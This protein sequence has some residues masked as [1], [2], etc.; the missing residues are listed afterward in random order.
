MPHELKNDEELR[1]SDPDLPMLDRAITLARTDFENAKPMFEELVRRGSVSAM[2]GLALAFV[3]HDDVQN[4]KRWYQAA[5]E[6][7][8]ST[9]LFSLAMLEWR[10]GFT[11]KAEMLWEEGASKNDGPSIFRLA[12]LYLDS[13]DATKRAQVR[14]LL[15]KADRLG[16]VRATVLLGK[17]LASGRYGIQNIPKGIATYLRATFSVFRVAGANANDRR[18]W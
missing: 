18:L 3:K 5:H 4:A 1:D 13:P 8:S 12:V 2:V 7:G 16:Q 17:Q 6:K 14:T 10:Q 15:E 11:R 9:A